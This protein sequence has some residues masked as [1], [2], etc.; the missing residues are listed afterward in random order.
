VSKIRK[1]NVLIN[2]IEKNRVTNIMESF[3][4][5]SQKFDDSKYIEIEDS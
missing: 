1:W 5:R 2:G 3:G 4:K